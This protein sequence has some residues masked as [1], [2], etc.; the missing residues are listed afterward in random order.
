M[1][2]FNL[3][4]NEIFPDRPRNLIGALR[5]IWPYLRQFRFKLASIVALG[6]FASGAELMTIGLILPLLETLFG[7]EGNALTANTPI[8]FVVDWLTP[9]STEWRLRLLV[10][11]MFALQAL[12]EL[13]NFAN[14]RLVA[15]V[16]A[17]LDV[18]L[19][20]IVYDRI[21]SMDIR[22]IY[23]ETVSRLFAY[24]NGFTVH[25][26]QM[27]LSLLQ[28]LPPALMFCVY[29][30]VLIRISPILTIVGALSMGVVLV[31]GN[32]IMSR[33]RV[34]GERMGAAAVALTHRAFE[35]L[36][37]M[38]LIRMFSRED[39]ARREFRK[40][41]EKYRRG[42]IAMATL[43]A[44]MS[45]LNQLIGLM[46]LVIIVWIGTAHFVVDGQV[47]SEMIGLYLIVLM[48]LSGPI[49]QIN[50]Q[51]A[52]IATT[53]TGTHW[54]GEFLAATNEPALPQGSIVATKLA[55][56]IVFENVTFNYSEGETAAISNASFT[57]AKGKVTALVGASGAGKSTTLDLIYRFYDPS[58]GRIR[59]AD[60]DIRDYTIESWRRR[61]ASVSQ[62]T[63]LFGGSLRENIRYGN[64]EAS[65]E[66]VAAAA[67]AA[68]V[69]EFVSTL[70]Q[71]YETLLG[72]RGMRL[73]GGQAQR[74]A[75]ARAILANPDVLILDEATSA[76]DAESE[77]LVQQALAE[78]SRD[79]TV[80]VVAH[81]LATVKNADAIIVLE[82]GAV[83]EVGTHNELIARGGRYARF[84]ELQDLRA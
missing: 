5:L 76:Q 71:G 21:L 17:D 1:L 32:W 31:L 65:D 23:G 38:R 19:R 43:N 69:E 68:N 74:V 70:P 7:R 50:N 27:V 63:F 48:R 3:A 12:R 11:V 57:I 30:G 29:F 18:S 51:R 20:H 36:S 34:W 61:L 10:L 52:Q 80:I 45:P 26:G 83:I 25:A 84:V 37:A 4:T 40:D 56:D 62:D 8:A 60:Q 22:R 64:L 49:G 77:R 35:T 15:T 82:R 55:G 46:L 42:R 58:F 39:F 59:V 9:F 13:T 73:S 72:D 44:M 67:R 75:I 66:E 28:A 16:G 47:F 54:I 53:I 24:L 81:R 78:L 79:R 2:N 14:Q 41:V 33:H 6:I